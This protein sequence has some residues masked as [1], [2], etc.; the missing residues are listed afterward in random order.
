MPKTIVDTRT[1]LERLKQGC[2]APKSPWPTKINAQEEAL[3]KAYRDEVQQLRE[4]FK[5]D[6][7][8]E[9]GV[10]GNPK[11]QRCFE[12]AWEHGHAEGKHEVIIYFE[13]FVELIK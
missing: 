2:Y 8:E 1:V 9:H 7:F 10:T 11:A 12:L 13:D 5:Q 4:Q 6:L 3:K